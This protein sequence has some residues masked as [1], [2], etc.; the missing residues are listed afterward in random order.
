MRDVSENKIHNVS[1]NERHDVAK[2]INKMNGVLGHF[3][4]I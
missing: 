1:E 2:Q 3:V 4:H